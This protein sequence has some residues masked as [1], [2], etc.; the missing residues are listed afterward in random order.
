MDPG[1]TLMQELSRESAVIG[2]IRRRGYDAAVIFTSYHQSSL[3]AA[4][5]CYLAGIPLGHAASIDGPGSLLTSRHRHPSRTLHEVERGL[6][7]V[8]GVGIEPVSD[9]LVLSPADED[10]R[11]ARATVDGLRHGHEPVIAIHPGCSCPS[12]TYP[13]EHFAR[14]ALALE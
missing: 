4:S 2:E 1:S 6:D 7:L 12:R 8:G 11:L 13:P 9:D 10:L 5:L 3:P 14:P